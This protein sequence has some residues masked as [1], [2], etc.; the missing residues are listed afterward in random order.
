MRNGAVQ[1]TFPHAVDDLAFAVVSSIRALKWHQSG[2]GSEYDLNGNIINA[3]V[4]APIPGFDGQAL[5]GTTDG[6]SH[7]Y[8]GEFGG[9]RVWET[10]RNWGNGNVL[11]A[12]GSSI[13]GITYDPNGTLWLTLDNTGTVENRGLNGAVVSSFS[14]RSWSM[15]IARLRTVDGHA[16]DDQ[17]Q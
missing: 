3:N 2:N 4:F 7:N 12:T 8:A 5:D 1:D 6:T 17:Q 10:D 9:G 13:V 11:F 14:A 16:L 15:G